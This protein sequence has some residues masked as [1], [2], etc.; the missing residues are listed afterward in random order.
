MLWA[1]FVCRTKHGAAQYKVPQIEL[2]YAFSL[3]IKI[4]AMWNNVVWLLLLLISDG[5]LV[6]LF[7]MQNFIIH[8]LIVWLV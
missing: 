3:F 2:I 7:I 4:A 5:I 1:R 8:I 6:T